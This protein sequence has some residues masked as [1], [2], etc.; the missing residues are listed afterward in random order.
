MALQ[1]PVADRQPELVPW[2][3]N[4]LLGATACLATLCLGS[5]LPTETN[6][7]RES[8]GL[9]DEFLLGGPPGRCYARFGACS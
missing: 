9:E 8:L 2:K 6:I 1:S 7:A 3:E 4:Q 5:L